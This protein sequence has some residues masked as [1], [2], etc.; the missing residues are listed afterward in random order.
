MF[1]L[2]VR[3]ACIALAFATF[4]A[5]KAN[6]LTYPRAVLIPNPYAPDG[7][8]G[9]VFIVAKPGAAPSVVLQGSFSQLEPVASPDGKLFA[10]DDETQQSDVQPKDTKPT[11]S[12]IVSDWSGHTTMKTSKLMSRTWGDGCFGIDRIEWVDNTRIGVGCFGGSLYTYTTILFPTSMIGVSYVSWS[13]TSFNWSP[14]RQH[15]AYAVNMP[16]YPPNGS[17]SDIVRIDDKSMAF[18]GTTSHD[19]AI[20]GV[21][22]TIWSP[23]GK[24]IAWFDTA[25]TCK[26]NGSE[27][28]EQQD[29]CTPQPAETQIGIS[30]LGGQ[31]KTMSLSPACLGGENEAAPGVKWL[32]NA[33]IHLKCGDFA[34]AD[35]RFHP[36]PN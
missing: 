24:R 30:E 4:N 35:L 16:H 31:S 11:S 26:L 28:V 3:S 8:K 22:S 17:R 10:F 20:H 34:I 27:T 21:G 9:Q 25:E 6:D 1:K 33:H 23:D 18:S 14:N 5:A 13:K 36:A 7:T 12:L 2:T 29:G 19:D 32:D 15:V